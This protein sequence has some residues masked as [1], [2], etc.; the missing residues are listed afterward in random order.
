MLM[1]RE[2]LAALKAFV[3]AQGRRLEEPKGEYEVMRWSND[4]G[5]PKPIIYKKHNEKFLTVNKAAEPLY[6]KWLRK[7][8]N[9]NITNRF[10]ENY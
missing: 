3:E 9:N 6:R 1:V 2:D 4:E 10:G 7:A 8:N 5:E